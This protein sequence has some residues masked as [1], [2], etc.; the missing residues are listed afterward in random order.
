MLFVWSRLNTLV[1]CLLLFQYCF[2]A[3]V[4]V[5]GSSVSRI[6]FANYVRK[7][8]IIYTSIKIPRFSSQLE[9]KF[10]S[11]EDDVIVLLKFNGL[12]TLENCDGK[13]QL[14]ALPDVAVLL[15][16]QPVYSVLY[17]GTKPWNFFFNS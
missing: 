17:I 4:T 14:Q 6:H 15:D 16:R 3:F 9:V 5:T 13:I 12:P 10:W 2:N 7:D 8:D 1:F 11:T